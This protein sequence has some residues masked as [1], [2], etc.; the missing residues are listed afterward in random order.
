MT[1][2]KSR[3]DQTLIYVLDVW[4]HVQEI[5]ITEKL[6]IGEHELKE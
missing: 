3:V 4:E 6:F 5:N 2:I 1:W